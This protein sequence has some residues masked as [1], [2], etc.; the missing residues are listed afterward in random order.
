[1]TNGIENIDLNREKVYN[2]SADKSV[3][4]P[5][6][7]QT[8]LM[9]DQAPRYFSYI[10]G[11][12]TF[13]IHGVARL[14]TNDVVRE[15]VL[16]VLSSRV[17][18]EI[19]IKAITASQND[20]FYSNSD[21]L[22]FDIIVER[23]KSSSLN[24]TQQTC[25]VLS[26]FF[27]KFRQEYGLS[28][29]SFE[30]KELVK[31][32]TVYPS[33]ED[34][35]F[36]VKESIIREQLE[37]I[38]W[39][40]LK[41]EGKRKV[42]IS[43]IASAYEDRFLTFERSLQKIKKFE[44]DMSSVLI[45][46]RSYVIKSFDSYTAEELA[47]FEDDSFLNL[48]TNYSLVL[49]SLKLSYERPT[50]GYVF[51]ITAV[52]S[53]S[54][55]LSSSEKF[56][57][58][59]LSAVKEMYTLKHI[60]F[61][62]QYR[63]GSILIRNM[64]ESTNLGIYHKKE[65]GTAGLT[66]LTEDK[67]AENYLS[68]IYT[69]MTQLDT[70]EIMDF[71]EGILGL[72]VTPET[73]H[74][75][76]RLNVE[77]LD[78]EYLA[79]SVSEKVYIDIGKYVSDK[80]SPNIKIG[81]LIDTNKAKIEN[82]FGTLMGSTVVEEASLPLFYADEFSG[83]RMLELANNPVDGDKRTL[84]TSVDKSILGA[85]L[86]EELKKTFKID[87]HVI[88][89]RWSIGDLSGLIGLD[90]TYATIPLVGCKIYSDFMSTYDNLKNYISTLNRGTLQQYNSHI[91][92]EIDSQFVARLVDIIRSDEILQTTNTAIA[93]IWASSDFEQKRLADSVL[94]E[95][96]A[97]AEIKINVT[98][99]FLSRLGFITDTKTLN[100]ITKLLKE[101]SAFKLLVE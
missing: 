6:R 55:I 28:S 64:R 72:V 21:S 39:S 71:A 77:K 91:N 94:V 80:K 90:N 1:M 36:E 20:T 46:I 25:T 48:A 95:S 73:K 9:D 7:V 84:Y 56:R 35:I 29:R 81:Y 19:A 76:F 16:N 47:F 66:R 79:A 101:S 51:W 70:N 57:V 100:K 83:K 60:E 88:T 59:S 42:G 92:L 14:L 86:D 78:L 87:N 54:S 61:D 85:K 74:F 8:V 49:E 62:G 67:G 15:S 4:K 52:Q 37:L 24:L 97:R 63:K 22:N 32:E 58:Q 82:N 45:L 11:G 34:L 12:D 18:M 53:V 31:L 93:K 40:F 26:N 10:H 44:R 50:T 2:V 43:A 99:F 33:T 5:L 3:L 23:L 38:D 17:N 89:T 27:T 96:Y 69:K 30:V 75:L 41:N 98:F 68:P 65:V 13:D